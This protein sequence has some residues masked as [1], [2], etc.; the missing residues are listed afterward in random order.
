[1]RAYLTASGRYIGR[2]ADAGKEGFTGVDIPDD[3]PGLLAWINERC[4]RTARLPAPPVADAKTAH[5]DTAQALAIRHDERGKA[6]P[7]CPACHHSERAAAL[8]AKRRDV[9]AI[10]A[11]IMGAEG[12]QMESL[13]QSMASRIGDL[14]S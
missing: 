5:D 7:E 13:F 1:M 10:A 2:Q 3:K 11:W 14:R 8:V 9:E 6:M 12:W 4:E